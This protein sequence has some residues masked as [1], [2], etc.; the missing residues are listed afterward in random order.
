MQIRYK[1]SEM[2]EMLILPKAQQQNLHSVPPT[3]SISVMTSKA[4][5][6]IQTFW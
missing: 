1:E 4:N 3:Q 5:V 6:V 2:S